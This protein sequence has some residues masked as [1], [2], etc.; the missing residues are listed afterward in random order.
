MGSSSWHPKGVIGIKTDVYDTAYLAQAAAGLRVSKARIP[1]SSSGRQTEFAAA[2]SRT[3]AGETACP[4]TGPCDAYAV[5]HTAAHLQALVDRCEKFRGVEVPMGYRKSLALCIVDSVQSTG[6]TYSSVEKVVAR[7]RAHRLD[8]GGDPNTDGTVE[9]LATFTETDGPDGWAEKIG[10][11][12]R[13]STRGGVLKAEAIRDAAAV[14]D[15]MG[16]TTAASLR[17]ADAARRK[18]AESSWCAVT[19]QRSGITWR[20]LLMLDGVPGVKPDRMICRFVEDSLQLR[21]RSVGAEFAY[22]IVMGAAEEMGM[23]S[24]AL[25]HAIWR[26][27]R[28]RR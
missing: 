1:F 25:D 28:G 19:G 17:D 7:Y 8:R 14:L 21:R 12:N 27:Q 11:R 20:Y 3:L 24:T 23:S 5:S 15:G 26:F 10:T 16:I 13:T 9:L 6:V 18:E 22:A 2:F 4:V